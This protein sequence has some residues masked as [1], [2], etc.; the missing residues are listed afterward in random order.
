MPYK[1]K[2]L[3]R[4]LRKQR[5]WRGYKSPAEQLATAIREVTGFEWAKCKEIVKAFTA[6]LRKGLERD[7]FVT[8]PHI[9]RLYVTEHKARRDTPPSL[10]GRY[11][12][13]YDIVTPAKKVVRFETCKSLRRSLYDGN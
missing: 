9:G 7:G 6:T 1:D 11:I 10:P 13:G 8:M 12:G 2:E 5:Y 3:G 4:E